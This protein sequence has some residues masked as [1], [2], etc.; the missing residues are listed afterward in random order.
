MYNWDYNLP[1]DWKPQTRDEWV[2]Y[3]QRILTHGLG[4]D[5]IDR[6]K[7]KE[8]WKELDIPH[9]TRVFLELLLWN[10]AY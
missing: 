10:K 6:A 8:Y 9:D 1:K 2:W 3:F 4:G 7:L 5:K